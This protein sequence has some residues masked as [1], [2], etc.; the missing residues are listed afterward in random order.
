[1]RVVFLDI[2]AGHNIAK[3]NLRSAIT[4]WLAVNTVHIIGT[5]L[6]R[7]KTIWVSNTSKI[8]GMQV[9]RGR[10]SVISCR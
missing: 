10:C 1:M 2:R 8:H 7:H 5:Q 9:I 4:H 3:H 6:D